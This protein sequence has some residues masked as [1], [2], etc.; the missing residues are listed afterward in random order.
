MAK[1][2]LKESKKSLKKERLVSELAGHGHTKVGG[3][4][5]KP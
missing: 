3:G 5:V 2:S 1:K 4:I